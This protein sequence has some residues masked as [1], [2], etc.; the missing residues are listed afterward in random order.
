M[1]SLV[2]QFCSKFQSEQILNCYLQLAVHWNF[3]DNSFNDVSSELL[4]LESNVSSLLS[5][6]L[7][8]GKSKPWPEA[9]EK[10][11]GSKKMDVGPLKEY[12]EPLNKWM[13]Q[14][15]EKYEYPLGWAKEDNNR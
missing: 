8:L 5:D 15:R 6:M 12:F 2:V 11:T 3:T 4:N 1:D 14:Q 9:L 10:L 7:K 13:K